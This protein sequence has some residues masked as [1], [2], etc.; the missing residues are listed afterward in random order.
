MI[1]FEKVKKCL[2]EFITRFDREEETCPVG[3]KALGLRVEYLSGVYKNNFS[4]T[5]FCASIVSPVAPSP[6]YLSGQ[7]KIEG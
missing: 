6:I 7:W 4:N 3:L 1:E 2:M 5:R